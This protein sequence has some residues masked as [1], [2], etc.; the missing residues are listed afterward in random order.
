MQINARSLT[1]RQHSLVRNQ[2]P[3]FVAL[4]GRKRDVED[5]RHFPLLHLSPSLHHPIDKLTT[6]F[7]DIHRN[8]PFDN[9]FNR[10]YAETFIP[11]DISQMTFRFAE[12]I[13]PYHCRGNRIP[14]TAIRWP[15]FGDQPS[16]G[17]PFA[18]PTNKKPRAVLPRLPPPPLRDGSHAG[19]PHTNPGARSA[20]DDAALGLP[21]RFIFGL[22]PVRVPGRSTHDRQFKS[23][24]DHRIVH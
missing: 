15:D 2:R 10:Y 23:H 6:I 5:L 21:V 9:P 14:F 24:R 7:L 12:I 13:P 4:V 19:H 20:P 1:E 18:Y 11:P 3:S 17:R 8:R 22:F 16:V